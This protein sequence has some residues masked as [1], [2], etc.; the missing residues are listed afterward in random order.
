MGRSIKREKE[1]RW[2]ENKKQRKKQLER[3]KVRRKRDGSERNDIE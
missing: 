1:K 2:K 3:G